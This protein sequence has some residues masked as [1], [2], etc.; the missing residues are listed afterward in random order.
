MEGS[1]VLIKGGVAVPSAE[2]V[3]VVD[4]SLPLGHVAAV[5]GGALACGAK[6]WFEG[7]SAPLR[8]LLLAMAVARA[9]ASGAK[10]AAHRMPADETAAHS[11]GC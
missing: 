6:Q 4:R 5:L 10:L 8:P 7:A 3:F 2:E 1:K 9:V 11:L